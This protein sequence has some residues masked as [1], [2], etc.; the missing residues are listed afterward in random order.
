MGVDGECLTVAATPATGFVVLQFWIL[1]FCLLT[2]AATVE[3]TAWVNIPGLSYVPL[4]ILFLTPTVL[5]LR[6]IWGENKQRFQVSVYICWQRR[7]QAAVSWGELVPAH[8]AR[9]SSS[10]C[11]RCGPSAG[12][13]PA[14]RWGG[15]W[16]RGAWGA[17]RCSASGC[18]SSPGSSLWTTGTSSTWPRAHTLVN[19]W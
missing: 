1:D 15:L 3:A 12:C 4:F 6:L 18:D 5:V 9:P 14:A 8:L 7:L 13:G 17:A 11:G 10:W 19:R 16:W 2:P